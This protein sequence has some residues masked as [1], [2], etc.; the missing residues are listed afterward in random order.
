MHNI[1]LDKSENVGE[2]KTTKPLAS[3]AKGTFINPT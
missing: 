3:M 1:L 2:K